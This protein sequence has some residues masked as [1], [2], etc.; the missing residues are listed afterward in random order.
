[1]IRV[2]TVYDHLLSCDTLGPYWFTTNSA[3]VVT[4]V[5]IISHT[6]EALVS[7]HSYTY[8]NADLRTLNILNSLHHGHF[9][10]PS[11]PIL[12]IMNTLQFVQVDI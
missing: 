2:G 8:S 5:S 12:K 3:M 7:V 6:K 11:C 9:C 1:M 4:Q 10:L